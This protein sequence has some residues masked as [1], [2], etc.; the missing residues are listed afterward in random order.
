MT[1]SLLNCRKV[2]GE[3]PLMAAWPPGVMVLALFE[4]CFR[5]WCL[6]LAL[7]CDR[8]EVDRPLP[9]FLAFLARKRLRIGSSGTGGSKVVSAVFSCCGTG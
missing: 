4:E 7:E 8:A 6:F 9:V 2:S 5:E 3:S 1:F